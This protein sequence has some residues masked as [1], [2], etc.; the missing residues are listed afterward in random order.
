M[1]TLK[2]KKAFSFPEKEKYQPQVCCIQ[3]FSSGLSVLLSPPLPHHRIP[4]P[5]SDLNPSQECFSI[6]A[7]TILRYIGLSTGC[8][9]GQ[10]RSRHADGCEWGITQLGHREMWI[11]HNTPLT[12]RAT[13]TC[14]M[15]SLSRNSPKLLAAIFT[16]PRQLCFPANSSITQRAT[17]AERGSISACPCSSSDNLFSLLPLSELLLAGFNLL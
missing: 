16:L 4:L 5:P 1:G 15:K 3:I 14:H 9:M 12:G 8:W 6:I 7:A 13:T 10:P 2:N 11:Q 17:G